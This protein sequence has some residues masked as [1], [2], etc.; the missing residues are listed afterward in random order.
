MLFTKYYYIFI[1][2]PLVFFV[3]F[4]INKKSNKLS[5]AFLVAASLYFFEL[6]SEVATFGS[7]LRDTL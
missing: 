2:L 4:Y 1:F 5:K 6:R 3:Y 7:K